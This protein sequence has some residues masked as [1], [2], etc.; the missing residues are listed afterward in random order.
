M[1]RERFSQGDLLLPTNCGHIFYGFGNTVGSGTGLSAAE[2]VF[3]SNSAEAAAARTSQGAAETAPDNVPS[4]FLTCT[5][6]HVRPCLAQH[7]LLT[8]PA[9]DHIYHLKLSQ[10]CVGV[11]SLY[12]PSI[13]FHL[14]SIG[15]PP[16]SQ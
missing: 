1:C 5:P 13:S 16:C 4:G 2:V 6:G 8:V 7:N 11:F 9:I 15:F 12:F 3:V 14:A 10:L